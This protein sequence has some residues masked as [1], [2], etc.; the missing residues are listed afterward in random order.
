SR[1]G[2]CSTSPSRQVT[3]AMP[4]SAASERARS[5]MAWVMSIPVACFTTGAKAQT[6]MP[7]PH[8]TSRTS[9][10]GP[11]CAASTIIF[12]AASLAIGAAVENGVAWRVNWSR[13]RLLWVTS[14]IAEPLL[15]AELR[16]DLAQK[17][18]EA[19]GR[20]FM[21]HRPEPESTND[22]ADAELVER[23]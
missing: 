10:A 4:F 7:P 20:H 8:A 14:V 22:P 6:T 19:G 5:S 11:A 9:S 2:R 12:S 17:Q 15:M 3:L 18:A 21:R 1:Y 23:G 16:G 13:I